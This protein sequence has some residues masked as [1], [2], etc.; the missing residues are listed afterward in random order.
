MHRTLGLAPVPVICRGVGRLESIM[1]EKRY[2]V[3]ISSTYSDLEEERRRVV[4]ALLQVD[5]I[6]VG[7]E[8]FPA[9][10]EEQWRFIERVISD[11]DYYV[12]IIAGR[13]GSL[14]AEG[15]SFTEKEFDY[16]LE[17][18][19]PIL[20]FIHAD[21]GTLMASKRELDKDAVEKLEAF[22]QRVRTGRLVKTWTTPSELAERVV[23]SLTRAKTSHPTR[24]WI[25]GGGPDSVTLLQEVNELRKRNQGLDPIVAKDRLPASA[26][27]LL[28]R[29]LA[30]EIPAG[31]RTSP[32]VQS[33]GRRFESSKHPSGMAFVV[34]I[35]FSQ[36][37]WR[38]EHSLIEHQA[39]D[40]SSSSNLAAGS[41]TV[42]LYGS[43]N[44]N[45]YPPK[46][47]GWSTSVLW[48]RILSIIG[49]SMLS[50]WQPESLLGGRLARELTRPKFSN[51]PNS[52]LSDFSLE[53]V[54]VQFLALGWIEVKSFENRAGIMAPFWILTETG[55]AELLAV[56]SLKKANP[57]DGVQDEAPNPTAPADQ[58][59]PLPG[60]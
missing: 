60:C 42:T 30:E 37:N 28:Q 49:P 15:I 27:A 54:K 21:A 12:L 51:F 46:E 14:T 17:K 20:A 35:R 52:G 50:Q 40:K 44:S 55:K 23:I 56:R 8:L 3:F 26:G 47:R 34:F 38:V 25:R 18:A 32:R 31:G 1:S 36:C 16:A 11:C 59:A 2:Q 41:E 7:M 53:T 9:A 5:C 6:P 22:K 29:P 58:K 48:N 39:R 45:D 33:R 24:G 13:Y 19:I 4:E 43:L 10:D 57:A